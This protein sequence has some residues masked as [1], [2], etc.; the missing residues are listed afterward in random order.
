MHHYIIQYTS[1]CTKEFARNVLFGTITGI[2]VLII[3][4]LCGMPVVDIAMTIF[5]IPIYIAGIITLFTTVPI[6][7]IFDAIIGVFTDS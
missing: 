6:I 5:L 1:E 2:S 3:F 7:L 4:A